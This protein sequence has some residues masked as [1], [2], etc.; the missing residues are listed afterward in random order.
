MSVVWCNE[1]VLKLIELYQ[2]YECL[3]DT[4]HR[5]YKN[6]LIKQDAW[7]SIAKTLD[8]PVK[9]VESKVHTLRSQ[10]SRERKKLKSSKKTGTGSDDVLNITWFAYK[11]LLF[12]IKG[13]TT[14]GNKDTIKNHVSCLLLL[15]TKTRYEI[16]K[17]AKKKMKEPKDEFEIYGQYVASEL[18]NVKNQRTLLQAKYYINNILLQARMG[19]FDSN[20]F[21]GYQGYGDGWLGYGDG[22][23]TTS[24]TST[25]ADASTPTQTPEPQVHTATGDELRFSNLDEI[26]SQLE[27]GTQ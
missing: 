15:N 23:R 8:V 3:W 4:A 24:S 26:V 20:Y 7:D 21:G 14:T 1:R 2:N 27:D 6:K 13:E 11:P 17:S 25:Y 18:K 5:E 16:M 19:N 12:L 22:Y 10:F 9:E